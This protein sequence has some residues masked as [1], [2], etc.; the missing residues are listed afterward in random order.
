M[1]SPPSAALSSNPLL[2]ALHSP[3]RDLQPPSDFLRRRQRHVSLAG[4]CRRQQDQ[5]HD[6]FRRRIHAPVSASRLAQRF[7][8]YPALRRPGKSL[9]IGVYRFVQETPGDG[10]AGPVIRKLVTKAVVVVPAVSGDSD[11]HPETDRRSTVLE[12]LIEQ[13]CRLVVAAFPFQPLDV[14]SHS[15]ADVCLFTR[16][17]WF[18]WPD[19]PIDGR[20]GVLKRQTCPS[21]VTFASPDTARPATN[22]T[23][24]PV[25]SP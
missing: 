17:R 7:C 13:L 21:A 22:S 9:P 19:A 6:R 2:G 23:R 1:P 10:A 15:G 16:T 8:P 5:N 20:C 12:L 25:L 3:C 14:L 24:I 11:R 4:L 18:P